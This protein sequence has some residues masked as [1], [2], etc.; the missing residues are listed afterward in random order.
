MPCAEA[1]P[2]GSPVRGCAR[3]QGVAGSFGVAGAVGGGRNFEGCRMHLEEPKLCWVC[4][5]NELC[6]LLHF[7]ISV[8]WLPAVKVAVLTGEIVRNRI[9]SPKMSFLGWPVG[10]AT[11]LCPDQSR[12]VMNMGE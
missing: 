12:A 11:L 3:C 2:P 4:S 9:E 8:C 6:S 10:P 7:F 1:A 5:H